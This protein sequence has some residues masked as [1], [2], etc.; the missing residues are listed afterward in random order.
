MRVLIVNKF[1]R[2]TGGA[3][4]Y[5]LD[6]ADGLRSRGHEVAFLAT[7]HPENRE[8]AGAFVEAT[9]TH[10][11]RDS[12]SLPR[13][14]RAAQCAYWNRAA[15]RAMRQ[16][17]VTFKPDVVS[18]HKLYPQLSVSPLVAAAA[19]GV[20]IVQTVHDYEFM[21]GSAFDHRGRWIDMDETTLRFRALNSSL[22]PIKRTVHR[23]AVTKWIAVSE[24][25][26]RR[27]RYVG[28][29]AEVIVNPAPRSLS[30]VKR[31]DERTGVAF[32]G[33]MSTEKGVM[34]LI[35]L[36]E[37]TPRVDVTV[38]G[39][40]PLAGDF[41]RAERRL[42]NLR[43]VG[44]LTRAGVT[45]LFDSAVAVVMPSLWQEPGSLI[46]LEAMATGTPIVAYEVGGL[47][48]YVAASAAGIV[49][50]PSVNAMSTAV[51]TLLSDPATWTRMSEAALAAVKDV[52]SLQK[53][54]S[55]L[56]RAFSAAASR[57]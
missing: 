51:S 50:P 31:R 55:K 37:I 16:L 12:L 43:Y 47:S 34:H 42:P 8:R 17:I 46:A 18:A 56:E 41:V 4:A 9:V 44:G 45:R 20:P 57:A 19:A 33:R 15:Y 1:V 5:C 38:A 7:Q 11:E 52:H 22:F 13:Q 21:S 26:S 10:R 24:F 53:H 35:R 40:G 28:I 23:R 25:V 48:E 30:I 6:I 2:V 3:D 29:D 36:A 32:A 39:E 54:C 27:L 14:L 49:V